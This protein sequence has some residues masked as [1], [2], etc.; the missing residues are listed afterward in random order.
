MKSAIVI[1]AAAIATTVSVA[2]ARVVRIEITRTEPFAAGQ[3]FGE[4]GAYEKVAGRFYGELDPAAPLNADIVDIDKAPR[5]AKGRV[6]IVRGGSIEHIEIN[7]SDPWTE[8]DGERSSGKTKHPLFSDRAVR[9]ALALLVDRASVEAHIYGR[10]GLAT[11]N[12]INNPPR[13][14]SKNTRWEFNIDKANEL[15]DQAGWKRGADGVRA[16]DG[17]KLKLVFQTSVNAPRQKTQA[18]V[19]QACQKAGIDVELKSVTPSVYFSSD[20]ANPDTARKFYADIQMYTVG[21]PS[22]PDPERFMTTV[23]VV[24]NR[25][26]GK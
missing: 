24:G 23:R 22:V 20:A 6:E 4:T 9:Q 14:V 3:S 19:K 11:G 18:I 25:F 26:E 1:A 5:N 8:V 15:L 10:T 2:E 21:T 16:K 17:K 12:F 7:R 13:F